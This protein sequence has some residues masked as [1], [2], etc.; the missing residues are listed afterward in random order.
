[1]WFGCM[2]FVVFPAHA[3]CDTETTPLFLVQDAQHSWLRWVKKGLWQQLEHWLGQNHMAAR[4]TRLVSI[5][6]CARQDVLA[7]KT[8]A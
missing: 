6:V 3:L 4:N 7:K 5:L 8:P 2:H 1:M